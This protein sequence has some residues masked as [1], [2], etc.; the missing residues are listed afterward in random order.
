MATQREQLGLGIFMLQENTY[1]HFLFAFLDIYIT[2]LIS[3]FLTESASILAD[4]AQG[5]SKHAVCQ[6][7]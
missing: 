1:W 6:A 5:E 2:C 3:L 7:L 4:L